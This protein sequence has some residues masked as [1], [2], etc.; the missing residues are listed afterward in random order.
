MTDATPVQDAA[1]VRSDFFIPAFSAVAI[2][3]PFLLVIV[4][5][6]LP[7]LTGIRGRVIVNGD[8]VLAVALVAAVVLRVAYAIGVNRA[9]RLSASSENHA[10]TA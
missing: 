9:R 2:F 10:L 1:R 8:I 4:A 7:V 5:S 6:T 3:T